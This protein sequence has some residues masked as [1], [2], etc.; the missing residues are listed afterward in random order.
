MHLYYYGSI[1]DYNDYLF[2]VRMPI[3][4]DAAVVI[5]VVVI[6][7][8]DSVLNNNA[9]TCCLI[10]DGPAL[11]VFG[12]FVCLLY[13]KQVNYNYQN[14]KTAPK[15]AHLQVALV[16]AFVQMINACRV[17]RTLWIQW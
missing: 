1:I 7:D 2:V 14:Y 5:V 17:C 6:R 10:V 11:V 9:V 3:A 16:I 13:L 4:A 8:N 15:G 12:W